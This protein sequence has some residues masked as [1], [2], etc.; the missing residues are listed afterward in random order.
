[1]KDGQ[2]LENHVVHAVGSLDVL[3]NDEALEA[4]FKDQCV[5]VLVERVYAASEACWRIEDT[6]DVGS[7]VKLLCI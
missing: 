2:T 3:M 7:I 5:G 6:D 4:K 1:M